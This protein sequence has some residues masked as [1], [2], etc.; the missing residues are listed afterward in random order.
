MPADLKALK[1]TDEMFTITVQD[2]ADQTVLD[3]IGKPL[4]EFNTIAAG[5]DRYIPIAIL[6]RDQADNHIIGGLSGHSFYEWMYINLFF[7]PNAL[8]GQ[9]LGQRRLAQAEAIARTRS[10]TGIW[11]NTFEFQARG[12]YE[13]QGFTLFGTIPDH[14]H[15]NNMYFL[16][17]RLA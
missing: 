15:G 17:K 1:M 10:C 9:K 4:G 2:V 6:I 14:P 3:G 11:L 8:R 16:Q 7:I 13:K 5:D 12:F